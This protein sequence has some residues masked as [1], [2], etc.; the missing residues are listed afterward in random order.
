MLSLK[1]CKGKGNKKGFFKGE[2]ATRFCKG[3]EMTLKYAKLVH[4][5]TE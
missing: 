5:L 3:K 1:I 2:S 4:W